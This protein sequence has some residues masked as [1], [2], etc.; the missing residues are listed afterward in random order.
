M[1]AEGI[2]V[3]VYDKW[4]ADG[5][6]KMSD[7]MK[8]MNARIFADF[9][10][11]SLIG[12]QAPPLRMQTL[13]GDS[14]TVFP[15][16]DRRYK[17]LYFYDT[18]CAKCKMQTILLRN[19]LDSEDYPVDFYAI[20][21]ADKRPEWEKYAKDHPSI[22][23]PR[24]KVVHLWDSALE[25][26]FQRK[27]GVL[28]TPRLFLVGPGG[29]ILGRG[30]DARALSL[31][32]KDAFSEKELVY[33]TEA[34]VQMYDG[35]FGKMGDSP[36]DADV[37]GIADYI[38]SSTLGKADTVMFRQMTGDLMYY[39]SDK[40]EGGYKEGLYHIVK[41]YILS[42]SEVWRTKGDS[43]KVVGMAAMLN[44]LLSRAALG[45]VIPSVKV[46]GV[47][48]TWKTEKNKTIALNKLGRSRNII[49]FYSPKCSSCMAEK[50]A[51]EKIL[52]NDKCKT[53]VF[54]VDMD[55]MYD[56]NPQMEKRLLELFDLS[57]IPSIYITDKYGKILERYTSLL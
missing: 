32:L 3:C 38:A 6:L 50:A 56:E 29:Q 7:G 8:Q 10:R 19:F 52:A 9:N 35:L 23:A 44:D 54:L 20:Y 48:K 25:S 2:A 57:R 31:M 45:S 24:T 40:L 11:V 28:Q 37:K 39:L 12:C 17:V 36:T 27:Y 49:I 15:S 14:L 30:L 16:A 26:D 42:K 53:A 22:A 33:G 34:S 47:L 18:D 51:A 43:L 5:G 55:K 1:G 21:V 41:E 13:Q 46:P 4:F